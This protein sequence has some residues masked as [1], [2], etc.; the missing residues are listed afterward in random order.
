[1]FSSIDGEEMST[2]NSKDVARLANVSQSTVSLVFSGRYQGRVSE[3]TRQNILKVAKELGYHPNINAQILRSGN[4]RAIAFIVP[5]IQQPYFGKVVH[6]AELSATKSGYSLI[7]LDSYANNHWVEHLVSL[8]QSK[9]ISGCIIYSCEI[10][11]I[12]LLNSYR[13]KLIFIE[14]DDDENNDII[15]NVDE[16]VKSAFSIVYNMNR[17]KIGFFRSDIPRKHFI[18]RHK[19]FDNEF[20]SLNILDKS[21]H[22]VY[23][24]FNLSQSTKNAELLLREKPNIVFCDDDILAGAIYRAAKTLNLDIPKD[25]AVVGFNDTDLCNYLSPELSTIKIPS[26]YIGEIAIKNLLKKTTNSK[27]SVK[28]ENIELELVLRAS[29]NF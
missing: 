9:L 23:S 4:S 25:V 11:H 16:A 8:F 21:K 6:A 3:K 14:S 20:N 5:D 7:L 17:F 24:S 29:T 27:T 1:M 15:L 10:K 18:K 13:N 12:E 2:V 22:V 19:L 26:L 28:V